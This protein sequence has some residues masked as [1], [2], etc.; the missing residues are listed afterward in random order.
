M[1]QKLEKFAD[2]QGSCMK[3]VNEDDC[4]VYE[5][6]MDGGVCRRTWKTCRG[7][8]GF[9]ILEMLDDGTHQGVDQ[10]RHFF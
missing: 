3:T 9:L 7:D 4:P 10:R 8:D 2:G 1:C 5:F 6:A